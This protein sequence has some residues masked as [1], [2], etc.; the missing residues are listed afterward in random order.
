MASACGDMRARV[1][2]RQTDSQTRQRD[3]PD[4]IALFGQFAELLPHPAP[5]ICRALTRLQAPEAGPLDSCHNTTSHISIT[6]LSV[7]PKDLAHLRPMSSQPDGD[8]ASVCL[9]Y[10]PIESW[11]GAKL[12]GGHGSDEDTK[13]APSVSTP[14]AYAYPAS[15][16]G[17]RGRQT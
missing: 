2:D 5:A 3:R 13:Q 12:S 11:A 16:R 15:E 14:K 10:L 9:G 4:R 6:C 17:E 8:D 7:R 1:V